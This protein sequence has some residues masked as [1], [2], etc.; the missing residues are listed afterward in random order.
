MRVNVDE[1][2]RDHL[3]LDIDDSLGWFCNRRRDAHDRVAANGDIT[4]VP[5]TAAAVDDAAVTQQQIIGRILGVLSL[6]W[7]ENQNRGDENDQLV[8]SD[9]SNA[10]G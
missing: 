10:C 7:R 8:R 1:P 6:S 9:F 5:G 3:P 4:A 2:R